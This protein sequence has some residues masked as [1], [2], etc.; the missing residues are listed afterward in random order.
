MHIDANAVNLVATSGVVERNVVVDSTRQ[1][2]YNQLIN[3]IFWLYENHRECLS[4]STI[5]GLTTHMAQDIAARSKS[6]LRCR[7]FLKRALLRLNRNDSTKSPI[8]I[9]IEEGISCLNYE[10]IAEFFGTKLKYEMVDIQLAMK[11]K[12]KLVEMGALATANEDNEDN[13]GDSNAVVED[14]AIEPDENGQVKVA[15][16][17]EA[18]FYDGYRSAISHLFKESGV[19]MS[20]EMKLNFSRYI[21]G[22]ARTN[23]AAKQT[24]GLKV[25]EGKSHMTVEVYELI[26]RLMFESDKK[27]HIFAHA[28]HVLDWNLM[29]RAENVVDCKITHIFFCNDS[30]TFIFAKSKSCD[31]EELLGPWHVYANPDNPHICPFLALARF[32]FAFPDAFGGSRP[33][34]EGS[35]SYS[36]YQKVFGDLL[37]SNEEEIRA[38][39]VEICDLGTHSGRK[40]VGTLVA[41][42]CTVSPPIVSICLRMG[43]SLGGV[44]GRY[45]KHGEAGDEFCGRIASLMKPLQKE[46]AISCPYFDYTDISDDIEREE[47][48]MEVAE[49]V[50]SRLPTN[51]SVASR[52]LA[53]CLF[54]SICYSH[55][56]LHYQLHPDCPFRNSIFFRD[57]P[58]HI[59]KRART[60]FPWNATDDT[61]KFTGIPPH[62]IQLAKLEKLEN[63]IVKLRESLQ[64]AVAGEL[65]RRGVGCTQ[66]FTE[67]LHERI[68]SLEMNLTTTNRNLIQQVTGRMQSGGGSGGKKL[69]DTR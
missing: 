44:L 19:L 17:L 1:G 57:I 30:L 12:K 7:K 10:I 55:Q 68:D 33:L 26:A 65:N 52:R 48:K 49:F 64:P 18:T 62:I 67:R 28:F 29:K 14:I 40:G 31:N 38:C 9:K 15:L 5:Q 53:L 54:A 42:G 23:K 61:P 60:A 25:K 6:H 37:K 8:N 66:F 16:R 24:L 11:Y 35:N 69:L 39:G 46:F 13:E 4:A 20:E 36:R 63:E 2:Y 56:K 59:I 43:W 51:T 45:F 27:E 47:T 34:F 41:A 50:N 22:S 21:R 3:L 58:V 32:L